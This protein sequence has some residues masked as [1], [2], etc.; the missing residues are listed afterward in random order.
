MSPWCPATMLLSLF[1]D[2]RDAPPPT[3]AE[4]REERMERKVQLPCQLQR[5]PVP[6]GVTA[7]SGGRKGLGALRSHPC[8][9]WQRGKFG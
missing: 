9:M 6:P 3:R 8:I 7:S 1:Q 5:T 2:P 4:T